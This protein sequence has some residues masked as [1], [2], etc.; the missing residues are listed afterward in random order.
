M[1]KL[2]IITPGRRV[3]AEIRFPS[4]WQ[5]FSLTSDSRKCMF[6]FPGTVEGAPGESISAGVIDMREENGTTIATL[7]C[8]AQQFQW[9]SLYCDCD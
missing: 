1:F 5:G 4:D 9:L 7:S 2:N 3:T 8:T 6:T